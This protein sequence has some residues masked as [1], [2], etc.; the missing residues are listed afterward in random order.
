MLCRMDKELA[1]MKSSTDI[2]PADDCAV[3]C[4]DAVPVIKLEP[5]YVKLLYL[6][7]S[8]AVLFF[9]IFDCIELTNG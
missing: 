5:V 3:K 4:S 8:A 2:V 6:A 7:S 1:I 9:F